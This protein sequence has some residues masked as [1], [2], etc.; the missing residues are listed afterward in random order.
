MRKGN[1]PSLRLL[2]I[3]SLLALLAGDAPGNTRVYQFSGSMGLQQSWAWG[4]SPT[5]ITCESLLPAEACAGDAEAVVAA[6]I[7]G[8]NALAIPGVSATA[9]PDPR[10][11]A[12]EVPDTLGL[13]L[14]EGCPV[15]LTCEPGLDVLTNCMFDMHV[16]EVSAAEQVAR[17]R[18][19]LD[20]LRERRRRPDS[21]ALPRG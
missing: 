6:L 4:L 15:E 9:L 12:L 20:P 2:A 19:G 13:F 17:L 16:Q 21:V 8:I 14:D 7:A 11:F 1:F 10:S 18:L 5:R 3:A